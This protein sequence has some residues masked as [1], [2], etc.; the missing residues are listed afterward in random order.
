MECPPKLGDYRGVDFAPT[1]VNLKPCE[2]VFLSIEAMRFQTPLL[3]ESFERSPLSFLSPANQPSKNEQYCNDVVP[4][5]QGE[6][7]LK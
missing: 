1:E 4:K 5:W 3:Q 2:G 7:R 6:D